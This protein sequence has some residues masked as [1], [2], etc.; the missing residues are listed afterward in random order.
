MPLVMDSDEKSLRKK[1]QQCSA[2]A[3]QL[4]LGTLEGESKL[5]TSQTDS[6]GVHNRHQLHRVLRQQLV[7][8][9]LIPVQQ[10]H[11]V[12]SEITVHL[13]QVLTR[14]MYWLRGSV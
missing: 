8:Q 4:N 6:W 3:Q 11:L 9:L 12:V 1:L 10:V 2:E 5:L 13:N 14:Y 7:E